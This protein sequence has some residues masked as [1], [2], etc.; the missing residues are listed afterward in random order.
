[1]DLDA[2][3]PDVLVEANECPRALILR[4][5]VGAARHFC[6]ETHV[7]EE[8][9]GTIYPIDGLLDY[10]LPLPTGASIVAVTSDL[11][12]DV[13]PPDTVR[14]AGVPADE[15]AVTAALQP[16]YGAGVLPDQV[17]DQYREAI[18][19]G[20]LSRLM[21]MTGRPWANPQLVEYHSRIVSDAISRA[22]ARQF[23]GYTNRPMRINVA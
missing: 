3:I 18:V 1:M 5:L 21:M 7:W 11:N 6:Q 22:R 8:P 19:S 12:A 23:R 2:L 15:I 13:I 20:A 17:A 9:V 4:E 14:F 16:A 10:S